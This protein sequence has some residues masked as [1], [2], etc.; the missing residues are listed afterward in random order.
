MKQTPA[1]DQY[2]DTL[3]AIIPPGLDRI[4]EVGCMRGTLAQAYLA[5]NPYCLW[6]G[7][8]IDPDNVTHAG[9]FCHR[10]YCRDIEAMDAAELL[11]WSANAWIFGDTLEHLR[12]PWAVL[13]K[14]R[15]IMDSGNCVLA[16]IPNAQHW[17]FQA[18]LNVGLFQYENDGLFDRTHLR[19]FTRTTIVELFESTGFRIEQAV[20]R[21]F[22]FPGYEK[23]M[24]HIRAM[25]LSSGHDPDVAEEDS[26]AYQYV[27]RAVPV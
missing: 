17:S 13:S 2:N 24:P 20:S 10:V 5:G 16:S 11:Q 7:I 8:D 21:K 6:T 3:L 14:L 27:V 12:D 19:F 15:G 22:N 9:R 1:Y 25:A 18:R 26:M 4:T 23:Y